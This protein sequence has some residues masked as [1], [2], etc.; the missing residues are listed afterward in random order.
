[1]HIHDMNDMTGSAHDVP[2]GT[3][4]C[5]IAGVLDELKRQHFAGNISVEYEANWQDNVINAGQY[6]GFVRGYAQK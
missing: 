5:N 6:I 2:V 3:G 4:V 1:M